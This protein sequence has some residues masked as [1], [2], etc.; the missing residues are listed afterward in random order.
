LHSLANDPSRKVN[1]CRAASSPAR[2]SDA[3]AGRYGDNAVFMDVDRI[4]FG[5]DIRQRIQQAL[6]QSDVVIAIIGPQ[7]LGADPP[8]DRGAGLIRDA[9]QRMQVISATRSVEESRIEDA[10]VRGIAG[11]EP[12]VTNHP[13]QRVPS[14]ARHCTRPF[15]NAVVDLPIE[16]G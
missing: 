16:D 10:F 14:T 12:G 7:W 4:P 5:K 2:G 9:G 11:Q 15:P 3:I 13:V 8:A 1:K 6:A